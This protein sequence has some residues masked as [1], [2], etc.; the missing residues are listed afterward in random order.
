MAQANFSF[1][2][3]ASGGDQFTVVSFSGNEAIS[4]LYR[5]EIEIKSP[6]SAAIDL[7][8]VLD[9]PARFVTELDGKEYPVYGVLSSFDELQT[10]QGYVYYRAVL[11]PRLWWLSIYK[12]NEIY[13]EEKTVDMIIQT[14]LENADFTSGTDFDLGGLDTSKF[15]KRNYV[16]QFG[17]SDFDFISRLMENEGIFYYFE[18]ES[19][20]AE[21]IIFINDMNYLKIPRPD[22]IFDVTAQTRRQHDSINAWSCR[23]QR[24]PASVTVRDFNPEQ[25]SL[26]ISDTIPIDDMGQG[27]EYIYGVNVRDGDEATYL[28]GIRAEEQLC[29]KTRYYGESSVTRLQA[30]YVFKLKEGHPNS[31]YNDVEYLTI[32]VSHEGQHLDTEMSERSRKRTQPT[33]EYRN[34]FVA[35]EATEQYRPP[36]K[37]PKPRFFGTMT[38]FVYAE[39]GK[40][41]AEVD[42]EGRYRVHLPFDRAD[43]TKDSTDPHRKASTWIRM[44]QPYVG[45][46]QGM[47]FPLADGTEV[48]LTF[49]N[50]DPDQPII[51]SALPNASQP[52]LLTS[53]MNLQRTITA[54]VS[55]TVSGNTHTIS[56]NSARIA[57]LEN[58]PPAPH[59]TV[60]GVAYIN[61]NESEATLP[62][63]T[64][65][66][67]PWDG[68]PMDAASPAYDE[69][70]IKFKKY[71]KDF[72]VRSMVD[73][74][75]DD[76]IDEGRAIDALE[77]STDRGAGD[78][79][80]YANA[81]TFAYPQHERVYFIGTFHEDFHVKDDFM[82][83][84]ES[85]TGVREQFNFP[86]PGEQFPERELDGNGDPIREDPSTSSDAV[87]N[88][89]GI[90][91]V[92]ED[93]RWGDQMFYAYGRSFNWCAGTQMNPDPAQFDSE[94]NELKGNAF[95]VFNYGN[96]YTENLITES[97][98][99]SEHP[100]FPLQDL[101]D[102]MEYDAVNGWSP[103]DD[104]FGTYSGWPGFA[105]KA[106]GWVHGGIK[107]VFD[108]PQNIIHT[109]HL[110]TDELR[111]ARRLFPGDTVAEKTFGNT[112]SYQAGLAVDIHEGH[113]I[114]R[115]Y[116]DSEEVVAG[117]ANSVVH[118]DSYSTKVGN[119]N[120]FTLGSSSEIFCGNKLELL[121]GTDT[122]LKLAV[123]TEI[124]IAMD[125]TFHLGLVIGYQA[126]GFFNLTT[127][128]GIDKT[129]CLIGDSFA[130]L[131]NK[132]TELYKK[133]IAL[134]KEVG[135]LTKSEFRLAQAQAFFFG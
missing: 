132:K 65:M 3:D 32:E 38:A 48:L 98:G 13:T 94:G 10:V 86:A 112:Y 131:K 81:R 124:K 111:N 5:Y 92:S 37:T 16:C 129:G 100:D 14:V 89:T 109:R 74:D 68:L 128:I 36:R 66:I 104:V 82:N 12:T 55:Q 57:L 99:T 17:E 43:G 95:G 93:K 40:K 135:C 127:G 59:P 85:W 34:S 119:N 116:G 70:L 45:Q 26:D 7:D 126:A 78:N 54:Q 53:E 39:T 107:W 28:S 8:D 91:G 88:P 1:I 122:E 103:A 106:V 84:S 71:D 20:S 25:P 42:L 77:V 110:P 2:S 76:E 31:N 102:K 35:I 108:Y 24:L 9:N 30:G 62:P 23:K 130:D 75:L 90:R 115:N 50:G 4:S 21:K 118:G 69:A 58:P 125:N 46:D 27:T 47:Y 80:V 113:S 133:T 97:G 6:L 41:N 33:P 52:S 120:G 60:Q 19:G 56:Q 44:A 22:L 123:D 114:S 18:H 101:K 83:P 67:P 87:V 51:S 79:Y 15:L 63:T 73:N 121:M 117:D 29:S 72:N 11:V 61:E 49:I 64:S 105:A 134:N 96:G